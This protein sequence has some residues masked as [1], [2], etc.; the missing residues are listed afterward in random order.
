MRNFSTDELLELQRTGRKLWAGLK[1]NMRAD[2]RTIEDIQNRAFL[3][4]VRH[5]YQNVAMYRR[6]YDEH[7]VDL[8][9][10]QSV[11][12]IARLPII[13]K[14]DLV[15]NF[16]TGCLAQ[17]FT[18]DNVQ[19]AVSGGSSGVVVKVAYS[20]ETMLKR[21][22]TAY[23]IYSMMMGG[24][25]PDYRQVYVYTG[26]YP[27]ECLP[28]GSFPLVHIWTLDS[29]AD[30]RRKLLAAKPHMLTLY[31][32]KLKELL[33]VLGPNAIAVLREH[34]KC[35]NVKSEMSLQKERDD[36]SR[37]FGVPVLD[38]YG[39]EELAGTVAAQCPRGGYHIWEDINVVEV[40]DEADRPIEDD[41][42]GE[43]VATNLYNEAMPMIRYRQGDLMSLHPKHMTCACG[44]PFRM[45]KDLDGRN[46]SKFVTR[47][48]KT[49]S[50]G[51]LLDVGY[52]QLID[53]QD[54]MSTWQLIQVDLDTVHFSCKP[55]AQM[56]PQIRDEIQSR[57]HRLLEGQFAVG[58]EYVSELR[59]TPRGKRNQ[60][61]S[62]VSAPETST[63]R[64]PASTASDGPS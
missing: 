59:L 18:L 46:N 43:V 42:I 2:R 35:V 30:A 48:G 32:S 10:I 38:E 15:A 40:V 23:R 20:H 34:L 56:T 25:P 44:M 60:I 63:G 64:G 61:I 28:D 13:E 29:L 50:P 17:G 11:D 24:Y 9:Q 3:A 45:L 51:Y 36:W 54:A 8:A 55:T 16:P 33:T 21:V 39:S 53:F 12:D 49:F 57:V 27:F 1:A 62:H 47:A 37:L 14:A 26:K 52:T 58:V 19:T 4:T 7:G 22:I 6:K 5:A 31:P 41:R